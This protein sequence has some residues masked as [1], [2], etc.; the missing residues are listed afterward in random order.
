[1]KCAEVI[2]TCR[3]EVLPRSSSRS[4]SA[5]LRLWTGAS[6]SES[7]C[8][9]SS[10]DFTMSSSDPTRQ[11]QRLRGR[12]ATA[13]ALES[14]DASYRHECQTLV[15]IGQSVGQSLLSLDFRMHH[16]FWLSLSQAL[17]FSCMSVIPKRFH[18]TN[19]FDPKVSI[20]F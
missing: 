1:M 18:K 5:Q 4:R 2:V 9:S 10:I 11:D 19:P 8:R 13:H 20:R 15:S 12:H 7:S 17:H 14:T 6:E 3:L 16:T